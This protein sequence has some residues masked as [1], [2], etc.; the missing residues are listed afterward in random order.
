VSRLSVELNLDDLKKIWIK[1]FRNWDTND[2]FNLY[3]DNPFCVAKCEFCVH[4]GC[5]SAIGSEIYNKYYNYYLPKQIDEF[6]DILTLRKIDSVYF[7]GG[8]PS[9]MTTD[10]ME[11]IASTIPNFEAITEKSFEAHPAFLTKEKIDFLAKYK[12]TYISLGIQT[13]D[14]NI[15]QQQH[16]IYVAPEKIK[17]LVRYAQE[18]KGL[19]IN[20]DL[21][22]FI[23]T[24]TLKDL[25]TLKSDLRILTEDIKPNIIT[26]YPMYQRFAYDLYKGKT[27]GTEDEI[28]N[29]ISLIR[30]MY[31]LLLKVI[32][33]SSDYHF[34]NEISL[35]R[36]FVVENMIADTYILKISTDEFHKRVK[37]YSCSSFPFQPDYQNVIGLGGYGSRAPYSYQGRNIY[38][39]TTN[40][41]WNAKYFVEHGEDQLPK[42][43]D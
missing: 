3:I 7:G 37:K 10:I 42:L 14:K 23:E 4:F 36:D 20:C 9:L 13:F 31:K 30:G 22:V 11:K 34:L 39:K 17:E 6:R 2:T 38:Y 1:K 35:D 33:H 29:S 27:E 16:R 41:N 25:E 43:L 24:G 26:M 18:E 12:F 40:D 32:R 8:T 21:L 28:E 15:N 5:K 19:N